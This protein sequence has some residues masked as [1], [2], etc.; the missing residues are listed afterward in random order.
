M[1]PRSLFAALAL[2]T[3]VA[4]C[5][6]YEYDLVEPP[7]L[8]RHIGTKADEVIKLDPLVYHLRSY[9]NHLVIRIENPGDD[10]IRLLGD[11]STVVDPAGQSHPLRS[12]TAAP[13]SF[14]KLILP[15]PRPY[16]RSGSN[17]GIG[18]GVGVGRVYGGHPYWGGA[19]LYDPWYWDE[20]RYYTLYEP[21]SVDYW[22][23]NGETDVRLNLV[24]QR[25]DRTFRDSFT[26]HRKKM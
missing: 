2:S 18:L 10:P 7:D 12:Q 21:G 24:Y 20:P 16:Y 25:A 4:G 22:D 5:A 13:H 1:S 9:D 8:A 14:I 26:F 23:W 17:I 19:A 3:L 15:P 6:T 11:Q